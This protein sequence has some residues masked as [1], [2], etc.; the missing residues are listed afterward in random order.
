MWLYHDYL[1]AKDDPAGR[2][3]NEK[4]KSKISGRESVRSCPTRCLFLVN[5]MERR[6]A[7]FTSWDNIIE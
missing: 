7:V 5:M 4:G 2:V 6:I 1:S 3:L